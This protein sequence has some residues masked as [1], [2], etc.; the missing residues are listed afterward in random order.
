M[1]GFGF[2]GMDFEWLGNRAHLVGVVLIALFVWIGIQARRTWNLRQD[3]SRRSLARF[4]KRCEKKTLAF[5]DRQRKLHK[6][7]F[8]KYY[9]PPRR[10]RFSSS[11]GG[12]DW[13]LYLTCMM[14]PPGSKKK[15]SQE[16]VGDYMR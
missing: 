9:N 1:V 6:R 7:C 5:C 4:E 10:G 3:F 16:S 11:R 14:T 12:M 13:E 15:K 8:V 2:R